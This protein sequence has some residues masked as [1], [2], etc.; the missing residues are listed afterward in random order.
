MLRMA[1]AFLVI[2]MVAALFGFSSVAGT[3]YD[4]ARLLFFVFIVLF[5]I[6]AILG[7]NGRRQRLV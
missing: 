2:A 5:A 1:L 4:G 6:S 3:A 7:Y